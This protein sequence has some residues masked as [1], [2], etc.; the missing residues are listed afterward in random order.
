MSF[1]A[2]IRSVPL[3]ALAFLVLNHGVR[4]FGPGVAPTRRVLNL[5][6]AGFAIALIV[7]VASLP[8][9]WVHVGA[10]CLFLAGIGTLYHSDLSKSEAHLFPQPMG[11]WY[12]MLMVATLYIAAVVMACLFSW[13][14]FVR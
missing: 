5:V 8:P 12:Q 1:E 9:Y 11:R 6:I 10:L 2:M 7:Q 14:L 4:V 3:L 13:L